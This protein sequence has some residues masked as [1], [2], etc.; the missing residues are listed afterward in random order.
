MGLNQVR[1]PLILGEV[2]LDLYCSK[3]LVHIK[4]RRYALLSLRLV[5]LSGLGVIAGGLIAV[6]SV[7]NA[8]L[9][10]RLGNFGAVLILTLVS[11]G[12]L[13]V[14]ILFFPSTASLSNLPGL[15]EWYLYVGGILGVAILAAP[16]L[17]VPR[18]GTTST[19]IAIILGQSIIAM[20]IDHFGLFASPKVEI[21]FARAAGVILVGIGAYLVGR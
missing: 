11:I 6:Q 14:L 9:G 15:S 16:I 4:L 12:T 8:S 3:F 13:L 5:F 7:L 19:L 17:L 18:I 10:Q 20:L 1:C 2:I 21:N